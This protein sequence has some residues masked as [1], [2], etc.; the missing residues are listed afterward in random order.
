MRKPNRYDI[1]LA[2]F[3]AYI[4]AVIVGFVL[5]MYATLNDYDLINTTMEF[6]G[7]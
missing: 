7:F 1:G 2:L 4:V 5:S 6:W 3:G